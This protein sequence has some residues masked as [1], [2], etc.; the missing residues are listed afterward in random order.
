[1]DNGV[2][3]RMNKQEI[4]KQYSK[5][6]D[7]ILVAKILDKIQ[8][9]SQKNQIQITDFLDGYEQKVAQKVLQQVKYKNV[10]FYGGYGEA[11]RKMIYL[12]PEKLIDLI[13]EDLQKN[14][15]IQ[16]EMKAISIHL[17]NDLKGKYQ[18]RDYLSGLMKLGIKREKI[19]DILVRE[20]GADI[21]AQEDILKYLL[22]NLPELIRFQ[23]SEIFVKEISNLEIVPIQLEKMIILVPQLRL[24]VVIS[25]LLH[26][27]RTKVNEIITQERV[28]VNYETKTKNA[29]ML[30]IGDLLTIRGKGKFKIGE[31]INQTLKGKLRVEVEKY[32]S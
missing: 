23:K 25:E 14:K 1:M 17:P 10:I 20:N 12:F 9:A 22:I 11:E 19:G 24:D 27:S 3:N 5:E 16:K 28:L 2:K 7:K 6:E 4:V 26:I 18:H 13:E 15:M 31:I 32:V 8:F 29:T 21:L 30:Q